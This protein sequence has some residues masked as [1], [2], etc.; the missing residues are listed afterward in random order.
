MIFLRVDA[1]VV[2]VPTVEEGL[3]FYRDGLGHELVWRRPDAA[4]LRMRDSRSELVLMTM[5]DAETDLLVENLD[6]AIQSIKR[7][8]GTVTVPPRDID[9]G[10]I[11]G[12]RDPFGNVLTLVELSKGL[13]VTGPDGTVTGVDPRR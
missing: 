3:A 6:D 9:V 13:Y 12:I 7:A 11:A 2:R 10:R 5:I 8:G 1:V 4:G